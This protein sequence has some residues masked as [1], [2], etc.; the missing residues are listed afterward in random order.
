MLSFVVQVVGPKRD[1][2]KESEAALAVTM[3]V[4]NGKKA[5]LKAV[6]DDLQA[7]QV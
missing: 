4:L 2:L 1:A 3:S 7:L 6:E 5:E